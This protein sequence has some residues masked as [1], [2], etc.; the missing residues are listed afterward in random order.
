[1]RARLGLLAGLLA[2]IVLIPAAS[3]SALVD[4]TGDFT[5]A[6]DVPLA[7]QT[8]TFTP[9]DLADPEVLPLTG[10]IKSVAFDF[11]DG[12][13]VTDSTA[14]FG[15]QE[16]IF[17]SAGTRTVIMT[18]TDNEDETASISHNVRVNS[19]P[20]ARFTFSPDTPN[21]GQKVSLD[22][23]ASTD[24]V[25]IANYDWDLDGD[26]QYDDAQGKT[27]SVTFRTTGA[28]TVRLRVTDSDGVTAT[29]EAGIHVNL[30]PTAAF[31]FSPAKPVTGGSVDVTSVSTDPDGPITGQTWDLDGDGQ[32]D[33]AAG[34]TASV[35]YKLA[36]AKTVGLRVT[37][38]QGRTDTKTVSFT[39]VLADLP[40]ALPISPW[41]VTR[42]AGVASVK[43]T[44]IDLL[45]IRTPIGTT[46]KVKCVG[47]G[48]PRRRASS[49]RAKRKLVRLRWLEH[50]LR[51]G[52][53]IVI[54]ITEPGRIGQYTTYTLRKAKKPIR[55]RL[56]LYPGQAK[57][58]RCP[59]K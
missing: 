14:P 42:V 4:P 16:H 31:V 38:A 8:V 26:G 30:P 53:R 37:D 27:T 40:E 58:T 35:I 28:K 25:S 22:A 46:V 55:K 43:L 18:I 2:A 54:A 17:G 34:S 12:S 49:T 41:P 3:A 6:P 23:G 19:R 39:V 13:T 33:D 57:A 5:F 20:T 50:R 9:K 36:G 52:T 56:C 11:G 21:V 48:C 10:G 29:A 47:K 32:Y 24:N 15:A 1:M 7:G 45:S 51:P 59:K 44:R